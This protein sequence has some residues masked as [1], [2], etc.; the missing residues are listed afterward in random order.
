MTRVAKINAL[1]PR[2]EKEARA[3]VIEIG[4]TSEIR[5]AKDGTSYKFDFFSMYFHRAMNRL[6]KE[7][8]LR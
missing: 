4:K 6:A 5:I 3:K 1:I 8:K 7:N 2:A